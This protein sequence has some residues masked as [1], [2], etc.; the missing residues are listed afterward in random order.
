MVSLTRQRDEV[1]AR[2]ERLQKISQERPALLTEYQNIERDYTTLRKSYEELLARLQVGAG[3]LTP[4]MPL[5]NALVEKA[6]TQIVDPP[7]VPRIPI[8]PNRPIMIMCVLLAAPIG[9]FTISGLS[10]VNSRRA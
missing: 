6:K 1:Q 2:L 9:G 10:R 7:E 4:D 5:P 3:R 8:A